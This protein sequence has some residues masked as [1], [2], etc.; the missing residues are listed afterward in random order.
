M[1]NDD[2]LHLFFDYLVIFITNKKYRRG[3][4]MCEDR[5]CLECLAAKVGRKI[6]QFR[7]SHAEDRGGICK[8]TGLRGAANP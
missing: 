4:V 6:L 8:I 5:A 2:Q 7:P 3:F 1:G